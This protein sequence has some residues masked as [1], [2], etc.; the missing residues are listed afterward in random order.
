MVLDAWVSSEVDAHGLEQVQYK[1]K[2]CSE[3]LRAW[4]SNKTNPKTEEIKQL[5]KRLEVLNMEE[6]TKVSRA[7]FLVISKTLDDLL[8]K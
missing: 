2:K 3:V 6:T 1:I 8:L 4:C 7:E 5:Q